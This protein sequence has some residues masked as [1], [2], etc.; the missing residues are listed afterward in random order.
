MIAH[1]VQTGLDAALTTRREVLKGKRIATIANH[2]TVT[3]DLTSFYDIAMESKDFQLAYLYSPPH[4]VRG[5]AQDSEEE[6]HID[7]KTG[8]PVY[9]SYS[10][11][12]KDAADTMKKHKTDA[13]VFD[14]QNAGS[15]Y[16]GQKFVMCFAMEAAAQAGV[17]VIVLDRPN[18]IGGLD[19]EGEVLDMGYKSGIGWFE[20]PNRH[21]MTH[22]ELATMFNEEYGVR[23][24]LTVVKMEGWE[25]N[26]WYEDTRLFWPVIS[27][28]LPTTTSVLAYAGTCLFEGN[29]ISE[30]RGTTRPFEILGAPWL[31]ARALAGEM[32]DR[33]LPGVKFGEAYFIPTPNPIPHFSKFAG[34]KCQGVRIYI[35]DKK[36]FQPVRSAVHLMDAVMRADPNR[37]KWREK[38]ENAKHYP[39]DILAGSDDLRKKLEASIPADDIV[40]A[41][42]TKL[43][44]FNE[45]RKKYLLY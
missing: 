21:G 43:E 37:F 2:T 10:L 38:S 3:K 17:E 9:P 42:R 1:T 32:N 40:D 26:M 20:I 19:T 34:E 29:N 27:P 16:F 22:G 8:V 4:G 6:H 28:N 30:G 14:M 23:C 12:M 33:G 13:I 5:D 18:P 45:K 15:R 41:W 24:H 31:D 25:R 11:R 35:T 44:R 36:A 39:M 7:K